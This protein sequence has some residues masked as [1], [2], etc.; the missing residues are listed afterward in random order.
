MDCSLIDGGLI[1][2]TRGAGASIKPG[3]ERSGIP[4]TTTIRRSSPRSG[5]QRSD[6]IVTNRY[7]RLDRA[8]PSHCRPFRGLEEGLCFS[9]GS[10]ALHPRLYAVAHSA[11]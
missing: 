3:V 9:W 8:Y 4:R 11:G 10:A 7:F 6:A 1:I 2:Q 5:R